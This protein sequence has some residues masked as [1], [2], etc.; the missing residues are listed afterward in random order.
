MDYNNCRNLVQSTKH[1]SFEGLR[2]SENRKLPERTEELVR[3]GWRGF[4]R[5]SIVSDAFDFSSGLPSPPS[6]TSPSL[7]NVFHLEP[8]SFPFDQVPPLTFLFNAVRKK[9]RSP[10]LGKLERNFDAGTRPWNGAVGTMRLYSLRRVEARR[11]ADPYRLNEV[12]QRALSPGPPGE[13]SF[14]KSG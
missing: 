4:A 2:V 11:H 8:S 7:L 14:I 1:I 3:R 6:P 12:W 9:R 5:S 10:P 13:K